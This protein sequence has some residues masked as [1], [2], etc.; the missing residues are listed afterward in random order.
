MSSG[1]MTLPATRTMNRSP[2]PA[3][4]ASSGGTR[5]SLQPRMVAYV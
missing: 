5:E 3:S 1:E 4:N 2:K